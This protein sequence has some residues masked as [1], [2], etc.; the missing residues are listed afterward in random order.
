MSVVLYSLF[1]FLALEAGTDGLSQN[2][3]AEL[4]LCAM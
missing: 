2:I 3:G 4:P 1:D